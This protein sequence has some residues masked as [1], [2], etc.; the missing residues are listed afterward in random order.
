MKS[1]T[2]QAAKTVAIEELRFNFDSIYLAEGKEKTGIIQIESDVRK[3]KLDEKNLYD[4]SILDT[5]DFTKRGKLLL[6]GDASV[7]FYGTPKDFLRFILHKSYKVTEFST[8]FEVI[9]Y[10]KNEPV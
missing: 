7:Y 1:I 9:S 8:I 2:L 6:E 10:L 5:N 4:W 3:R